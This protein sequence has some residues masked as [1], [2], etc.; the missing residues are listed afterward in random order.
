MMYFEFK[1][2]FLP[3]C[4]ESG[5]VGYNVLWCVLLDIWNELPTTLKFCESL[6]PFRKN[7]KTCLFK[8]A[9]PP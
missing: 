6:A 9:F 3:K 8:I 5:A 4:C 1:I 2:A 7:L